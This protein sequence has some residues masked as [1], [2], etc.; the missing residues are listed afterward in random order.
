MSFSHSLSIVSTEAPITA[1]QTWLAPPTTAMNRYSM[2]MFTLNAPGL[3]NL[4]KC[5]YSQP[6]SAASSAA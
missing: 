6:E 4:T 1:P 2:P 3:R 5:A